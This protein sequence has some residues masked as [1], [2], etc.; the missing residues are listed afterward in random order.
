M[1]R[2]GLSCACRFCRLA[3]LPSEFDQRT[4]LL[5]A[6][7]LAAPHDPARGVHVDGVIVQTLSE[8]SNDHEEFSLPP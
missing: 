8:V 1:M 4:K 3:A 7:L 6:K 5:R 2:P